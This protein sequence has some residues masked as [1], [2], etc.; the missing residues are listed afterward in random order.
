MFKQNKIIALCIKILIG[1]ISFYIIY[2]RLSQIPNFKEQLASW[3]LNP[4]I[5]LTLILVLFIMP[6]NWGIESYKWKIITY[7]IE[8]ITYKIALKSVLTGICIGNIAPGRAM[9]F[10]AK[11]YF[12]KSENRPR[13]T[14]LHFINGLFQMIITVLVGVLSIVYKM[15]EA[16]QSQALLYLILSV[17]F[18]LIIAFCWCILNIDFIQQKLSFIKW[19]KQFDGAEKNKLSKPL[20]LKLIT[21]SFIRYTIF[22]SQFLFI[23]L[24][25]SHQT[26]YFQVFASIAAYFMLTSIIPMISFIE[27]AIRAAIALFVF[28]NNGNDGVIILSSTIVWLINVIVPSIIGYVIIL[29]EKINFRKN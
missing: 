8:P 23:Y 22:T 24:V 7:A 15:N 26:D 10:L 27:P 5:Y 29:K 14:I 21:L 2:N 20:I 1:V 6:I 16:N 19:F 28:K 18:C 25:L 4:H 17:G 11:I 9:E 3:A 12:F 13:V